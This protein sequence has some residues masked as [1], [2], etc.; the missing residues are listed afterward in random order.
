ML[1]PFALMIATQEMPPADTVTDAQIAAFAA[2]PWDKRD[3]SAKTFLG[4]HHGTRVV[5]DYRCSDLCPDYTTRIIH[6]AVDPGPACRAIGGAE[7]MV[8]VPRG[9]A[10]IGQSFCVPAVLGTEPVPLGGG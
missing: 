7:R 1:A 6:Y 2:A 9:I 4:I 8:T 5:V 10:S 3:P